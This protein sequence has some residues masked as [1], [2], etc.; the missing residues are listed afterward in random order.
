MGA[1]E[2][3]QHVQA[4]TEVGADRHF[5][6]ASRRRSH[7]AAHAGQL[8][9]LTGA[10]AGPGARH[11]AD[12][13]VG[14]QHFHHSV[15]QPVG[16]ALPGVDNHAVALVLAHF[17]PAVL[18]VDPSHQIVGFLEPGLFF[19]RDDNVADGHGDSAAGGIFIAQ[20]LDGVQHLGCLAFAV[21]VEALFH[22][23][24]QVLLD[25]LM[26]DFQHELVVH[27]VA[28]LEAQVLGHHVVKDQQAQGG[29]DD[30]PFG[31]ALPG[32]FHAHLDGGLQG[33]LGAL[34][35]HHG[36][37]RGSEHAARA[38]GVVPGNGQV[39]A[40][41]NHVLGR[42][43]NGHAILGLHDVVGAQHQEAGFRLG[44]H[45]KRYV[46]GHLVAVKVGVVGGAGQGMQPDGLA[47]HQDGLKGLNAQTVQGGGAVQK[48]GMLF[49]H[50]LQDVPYLGLYLFH[51]AL[52][53]FYV[54]GD[55]QGYQLFHHEGLEQFKR[56]ILGQAAL[57]QFQLGAYHD[58][59]TAGIVHALAQQVLTETAL[60]AA[61]QVG[62]A[63]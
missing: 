17:A 29:I 49:D 27:G 2:E 22:D 51:H 6:G 60:L 26:I 40:A 18:L 34:I 7:Q 48:N 39:V 38:L 25:H 53:G 35:S 50:L 61:Q 9:H 24:A 37:V 42:R 19:G 16:G 47:F 28:G 46:H 59:G 52:G 33:N 41:D 10:A 8:S 57:I 44:F 43:N 3:F 55:A 11:H 36:F 23:L 4:F 63:L 30:A 1:H 13:V 45:G 14:G 56:H 62:Q 15:L 21:G 12:G 20:V 5:D 32:A 58:Y 54:V 31:H